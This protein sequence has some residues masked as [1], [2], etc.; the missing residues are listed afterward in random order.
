MKKTIIAVLAAA[1]VIT[2]AIA[3]SA[4]GGHHMCM[5]HRTG[6][7]TVENCPNNCQYVYSE[8]HRNTGGHHRGRYE[9]NLKYCPYR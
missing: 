4:A 8:C 5:G 3:V 6:I 1:T 7:Y 9:R 2:G